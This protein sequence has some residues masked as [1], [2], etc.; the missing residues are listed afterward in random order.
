MA[1]EHVAD[2]LREDVLAA[3]DD[4]VVL[5]AVDQQPPLVVEVTEVAGVHQPADRLLR[6]LVAGVAVEDETAADEDV[7]D[8]AGRGLAALRVEDLQRRPQR[9]SPDRTGRGAQVGRAGDRGEAGLGRA[10]EVVEDI[11]E[12]RP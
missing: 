12:G 4:H 7:A 3:G 5:A 10:V 11:A 2:L 8:L 1:T 9:R 6:R